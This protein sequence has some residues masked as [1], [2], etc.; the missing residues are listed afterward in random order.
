M[1]PSAARPIGGNGAASPGWWPA[2]VDRAA[3]LVAA[4]PCDNR[5][6]PGRDRVSRPSS[7]LAVTPSASG[8]QTR[9]CTEGSSSRSTSLAPVAC[10]RPAMVESRMPSR[11]PVAGSV[12]CT[13]SPRTM[14]A[15]VPCSTE[16]SNGSLASAASGVA[17]TAPR[18]MYH[19]SAAAVTVILTGCCRAKRSRRACATVSLAIGVSQPP[20]SGRAQAW[21]S[22][23][24]LRT[25]ADHD[26]QLSTPLEHGNGRS[27]RAREAQLD[28]IRPD[29]GGNG[30]GR[31]TRRRGGAE[32]GPRR[33]A[34]RPWPGQV[35][36]EGLPAP[37]NTSAAMHPW[38]PATL[39]LA[40]Y[41]FLNAAAKTRTRAPPGGF[42]RGIVDGLP[43]R[44]VVFARHVAAGRPRSRSRRR[45]GRPADDARGGGV[46][47]PRR[48]AVPARNRAAAAN[49]CPGRRPAW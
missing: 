1:V 26:P 18:L 4:A 19:A 21:P 42:Q 11:S 43:E 28:A 41:R 32:H 48:A 15:R 37:W 38:V 49:Q 24:L 27:G 16:R 7:M 10:R 5:R 35:R 8:R 46:A 29:F 23:R 30:D 45:R 17:T 40:L 12:A 14:A 20:A 6:P 25:A 3:T 31:E 34:P 13:S 39:A 33:Q 47:T 22:R 44:P 36:R 9:P 2:G